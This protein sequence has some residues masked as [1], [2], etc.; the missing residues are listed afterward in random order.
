MAIIWGKERRGDE[1]PGRG[2]MKDQP[3]DPDHRKPHSGKRWIPV[4]FQ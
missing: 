3:I 4:H 2:R 1:D